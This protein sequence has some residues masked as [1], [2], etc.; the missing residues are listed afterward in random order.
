MHGF[1]DEIS[2]GQPIDASETVEGVFQEWRDNQTWLAVRC[3]QSGE[4]QNP[5]LRH[6][7]RF[8]RFSFV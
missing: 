4:L 3:V 8:F 5:L 1:A 7:Q 2:F 6:F